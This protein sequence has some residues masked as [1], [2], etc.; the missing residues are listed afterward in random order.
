MKRSGPFSSPLGFT[1][2]LLLFAGL[3]VS[4]WRDRGLAFSP[5][6]VTAKSQPGVT[7][8]GYSSHAEFEKR[9]GFCHDPLRATLAQKC[10]ECHTEIGTQMADGQGLHG[11]M[12]NVARCDACHPEHQGRDFD[13]TAATHPLFDHSVTHFSLAWHQLDFDATPLACADCHGEGS[14][15]SVPDETCA[16][17]HG[18]YDAEFMSAHLEQAGSRCQAC[19]D[20]ADRM[21]NFDHNS[22]VFPLDGLHAA[23]RCADCHLDGQIEDISQVC[24]DCHAEPA[25]HLGLLG[26]ECAGCHTSAGWTPA[27]LDGQPFEHAATT[28]FSLA[29]HALDYAGQVMNCAACHPAGAGQQAG[30]QAGLQISGADL[31]TC[32]DCHTQQDAVFMDEHQ[33]QFGPLCLDCHDGVDRLSNFDHNQVFWLDG[34]HAEAACEACHQDEAGNKRFRGTPSECVQ[35]HAE[36]EI[37]AGVFG[38]KCQYCHVAQAWTPANLR[39]HAF[40]LNHGAEDGQAPATCETCH[41]ANYVEYTCY[42]CHEHQPQEIEASHDQALFDRLGVSIQELPACAACHMSGTIEP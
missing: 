12:M 29:R 23:V 3:G 14:Y 16:N 5:G 8:E 11:K 4:L 20:G 22:T 38:L 31:Q 24:Q 17:C 41:G 10:N 37:H 19:H 25:V 33:A 21:R 2:T 27:S 26:L 30:Q 1:L 32:A 9:C 40:P 18:G 7:I 36:P 39:L 6:A 15:A 35:C 13:P 42:G 34:R 28:G